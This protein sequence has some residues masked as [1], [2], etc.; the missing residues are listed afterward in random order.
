MCSRRNVG[1]EVESY[2]QQFIFVLTFEDVGMSDYFHS[3][4]DEAGSVSVG[5]FASSGKPMK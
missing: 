4:P 5:S 3:H 1:Q 2:F